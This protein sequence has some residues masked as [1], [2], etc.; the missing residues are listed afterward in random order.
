MKKNYQDRFGISFNFSTGA[1][2][3][4]FAIGFHHHLAQDPDSCI[5]RTG[6]YLTIC[7]IAIGIGMFRHRV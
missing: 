7:N 6:I 4:L 1:S 3:D 2:F 5:F